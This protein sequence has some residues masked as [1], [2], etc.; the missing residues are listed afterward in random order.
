MD[1]LT[2][3]YVRR[4]RQRF[5]DEDTNAFDTLYTCLETLTRVT[6]SLLPLASEE[7]WRGLTGGRSVHL[8]EWPDAEAFPATP[9]WSPRWTARRIA[10]VGSSLRKA[11]N[12]RV[13]LPLQGMTVV[14]PNAAAL[15]GTFATIIAD[16]LNLRSV[17]L[18]DAAQANAAEYGISQ[19]LVVNARAAGPRLGKNVQLAIKGAKSGDWSVSDAGTVTAGG[20]DLEPHE[21]T[22]ETVVAA[23]AGEESRRG[24]AARRRV[25]GAGHRGH[26]ELAAEGTARDMVRAIQSARKDADCWSGTA[27]APKSPPMRPPW[28]R[29]TP[30]RTDQGRDP[31]QGRNC[32]PPKT[33][34]PWAY[35][36]NRGG[37]EAAVEK[38]WASPHDLRIL[39]R[40]RLRRTAGTRAGKQDRAAHGADVPRHGDPRGAQQGVPDH[41]RDRHQRQ[42]Q[43]RTHDRVAAARPRSAHGPLH[44]AAPDLGHRTHS[45]D[46][47]PV[48]DETFVRIWHEIR[49][50][51]QIVDDELAAKGENRMTFFEAMTVLGFAIFADA[52]VDVAI[53]EVGLGGI[54]DAT[55]VGDGQVSVVTPISLDHTDLLGDTTELIAQEKAGIIKPGGF[56]VSAAQPADA[57]QVLL[58][59]ARELEVPF[60]FEGIEFGVENRTV[61]VGGQVLTCRAWPVATRASCCRCTARTRHRTPRWRWPPWRRSSGEAR[62]SWTTSWS[63]RASPPPPARADSR[64]SAPPPA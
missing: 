18:I 39:R 31:E 51:L 59:K 53:I 17:T 42:D 49:P 50:Y 56:L 3:W 55:N 41:P 20:L 21:Y 24:R 22:L 14:A 64:S 60:K 57:A 45:I 33:E 62:R 1:T 7:I 25:P 58:D 63:W 44:L 40:E 23:G 19:Q 16:E 32:T 28:P 34:R 30:M 35:R 37:R 43:H 54:T 10:S 26:A 15:A 61:A 38:K 8:A 47:D 11:A 12:L 6:A 52:P 27:S 13:R 29:C 4:S 5:F 46:G 48:A 36:R 9:S 2:N